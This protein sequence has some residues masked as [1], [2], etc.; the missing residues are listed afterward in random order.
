MDNFLQKILNSIVP[1]RNA[2]QKPEPLSKEAL[3][4]MLRTTPELLEEFEQ[5]YRAAAYNTIPNPSNAFSINSRQAAEME[6]EE[7][8]AVQEDLVERIVNEL[9]TGLPMYIYDGEQGQQVIRYT[10]I[11]IGEAVSVEEV[12]ALPLAERPQLTGTCSIR[13]IEQDSYP[14]LLSMWAGYRSNMEK[15]NTQKAKMYYNQF[16]QGLDILDFDPIMYRIIDQNK[17]QMGYWLPALVDAVR[18]S[19]TVFSIPKTKVMKVPI[20]VLQMTRMGY[21]QLTN[22]TKAIVDRFCYK[23]FDLDESKDYF[24]KT[25]TYSSKQDFRNARVTSPKEVRELGEYLLFIHFQACHMASSLTAPHPIYGVSTTTEWVVR[26][27]IP[28]APGTLEMY[29]GLPIR[30]EFRVFIDGDSREV[31]GI[32][33]YWDPTIMKKRFTEHRDIHDTHDELT[34]AAAEPELT[35]LYEEKKPTVIANVEKLLEALDLPGQWSL[36]I[37][38]DPGTD[39]FWLID[40]ALA[41]NS[42]Y[43]S[44]CVREELRRPMPEQWIPD[45]SKDG[46]PFRLLN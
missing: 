35:R 29:K 40:M 32:H 1:K 26:E 39:R 24:I 13:D 22:T 31:L 23:A 5:Q 18:N 9:L 7:E 25:G 43:Y 3:A 34:Y 46:Q 20:A 17:N 8:G 30:P 14:I 44:D 12:N 27:F 37:M 38:H 2:D 10:A 33:N 16:R 36:D 19:N 41:E 4:E 6:R 42:T 11:P 15:G 28:A 45:F 21:E